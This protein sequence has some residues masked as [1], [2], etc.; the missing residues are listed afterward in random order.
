MEYMPRLMA[1]FHIGLGDRGVQLFSV[2]HDF[3]LIFRFKTFSR[4]WRKLTQITIINKLEK[5]ML[6]FTRCNVGHLEV[7]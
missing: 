5:F 1:S 7:C 3:N 2:A 6:Y 4:L